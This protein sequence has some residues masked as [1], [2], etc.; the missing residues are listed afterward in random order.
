MVY[1]ALAPAFEQVYTETSSASEALAMADDELERMLSDA[2]WADEATLIEGYRTIDIEFEIGE[3]N[4]SI[5]VDGDLHSTLIKGETTI[6]SYTGCLSSY[7]IE[8][9]F[10]CSL[11]GM[12][13]NQEHNIVVNDSTGTIYE[14]MRF[15]ASKI[16]CLNRAVLAE[17]CL[18]LVRLFSL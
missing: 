9:S 7:S 8:T 2:D 1:E 4:H 12:I 3:G 14:S 5:Y 6:D 17:F 16:F 18:R 10:N 11:T 13:P 15:L